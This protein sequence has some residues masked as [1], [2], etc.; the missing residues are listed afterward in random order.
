MYPTR[1]W[2]MFACV[3]SCEHILETSRLGELGMYVY[4]AVIW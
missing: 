1:P 2:L 3:A 4:K